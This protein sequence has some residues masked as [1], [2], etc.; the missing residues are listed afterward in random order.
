VKEIS[1]KIRSEYLDD[2]VLN[3]SQPRPPSII[4]NHEIKIAGTAHQSGENSNFDR[5]TVDKYVYHE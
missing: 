4:Y 2:S 1:N 5:E 3:S